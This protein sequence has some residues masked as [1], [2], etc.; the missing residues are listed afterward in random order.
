MD[1]LRGVAP[2]GLNGGVFLKVGTVTND[3]GATDTLFGSLM[4]DWF[5]RSAGDA[6]T[7]PNSGGPE[8]VTPIA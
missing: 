3:G 2:G 7:D 8:V 1:R 4:Q 6:I 5:L